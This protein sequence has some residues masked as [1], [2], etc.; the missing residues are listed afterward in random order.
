[1]KK[2]DWLK[3]LDLALWVNG[4][5]WDNYVVGYMYDREA[6]KEYCMGKGVSREI[7]LITYNYIY[8][9]SCEKGKQW[10]SFLPR[11]L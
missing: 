8:F 4:E 6:M 10:I 7:L 1:M 9:S 11:N 5:S 3:E 2:M